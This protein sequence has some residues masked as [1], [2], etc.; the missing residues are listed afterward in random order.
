MLVSFVGREPEVADINE[1]LRSA[2]L[3]TLT[4]TGGCG[5]TRLALEV[6]Q[7]LRTNF[8]GGTVFVDVG[9]LSDAALVLQVV[10]TELGVRDGPGHSLLETMTASLRSKDLLLV[11][12]NCE[13]LLDA[14]AH[15]VETLL[16]AAPQLR[17]IATSRERLRIPAETNYRVAP[18]EVPDSRRLPALPDLERYPAVRLFIDRARAVRPDFQLTERTARPIAELC[19]RLDGMPLAIELAAAWVRVL[20]PEQILERLRDYF[21]LLRGGSRTAPTRQQTL[22]ATLDWSFASLSAVEQTVL[23]RLSVFSGGFDLEA[24][25]AVASDPPERS[26]REAGG[27]LLVRDILDLVTALVD[28]SLIVSG[29]QGGRARYRLLEPVRQYGL[30][31]L[32]SGGEHEAIRARH[33]SH[34]VALAER[35]GRESLGMDQSTWFEHL[36]SNLGNL[37]LVLDWCRATPGRGELGLRLA[38]ALWRFWEVR[39]HLTEGRGWLTDLLAGAHASDPTEGRAQAL[40]AAAWLAMLQE[41]DSAAGSLIAASVAAWR[42]LGEGPGLGWSLWLW[43]YVQRRGDP[44]TSHVLTTQS[45][46][47]GRS[48]NDTALVGWSLW[49]LGE[50]AR[51][52][53]DLSA[54]T[55]QFEEAV[56]LVEE[57][58]STYAVAIGLRSLGQVAALQGDY[59]R[60]TRLLQRCLVLRRSLDDGWNLPDSLD[61]LAWVAQAQGQHRRAVQLYGAAEGLRDSSGAVLLHER[62][63]RRERHLEQARRAM[64]AERFTAAWHEGQGWS[65]EQA[66]EC[67]LTRTS[68]EVPLRG[69]G[70]SPPGPNTGTRGSTRALTRREAEVALLL[71]RGLTDRQIASELTIT[72]GTAGVHVVHILRKLG[73]HSRWQVGESVFQDGRLERELD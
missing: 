22:E 62:R 72:E 14:C 19:S 61:G 34:Y 13:H 23:A 71:A 70:R 5:K 29:E 11:L 60:A 42:A 67:A 64:G 59:W 25:E 47:R 53:G 68:D 37:R 36:E 41:G 45:L 28:K 15:L 40:F 38:G 8:P 54:A 57:H 52:Q 56:A 3:I 30:Q 49:L 58:G 12:D 69:T 21:Q 18:L 24:A 10:A 63:S 1:L 35:A 66:V 31:L 17:V 39:G 55:A 2:R 7:R 44:A 9:G 33:A 27:A 32:T 65:V 26:R 48:V 20:T 4:G 50:L 73:L 46:E 43:G 16:A 6:A 51:I